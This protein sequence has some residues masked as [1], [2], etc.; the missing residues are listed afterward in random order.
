MRQLV[1]GEWRFSFSG[2]PQDSFGLGNVGAA[3]AQ[4]KVIFRSQ[5]RQL[6]GNRHVDEL[7]ERDSFTL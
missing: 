6:F 3:G 2:A 7:I 1:A 4:T 5:S